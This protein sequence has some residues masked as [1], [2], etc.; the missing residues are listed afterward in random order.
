MK[1]ICKKKSDDFLVCLTHDVDWV[2]K[3]HQYLS[4]LFE[5]N[6]EG[7]RKINLYH[8][9]SLL[10]RKEPYWC[11][12]KIID[13]ENKFNVRSAFFFLSQIKS[14]FFELPS[15]SSYR[16][17]L[18]ETKVREMVQYLDLNG[19]EI[20]LHGSYYSYNNFNQLNEEKLRLEKVLG[21]KVKSVRQHYLNISIPETWEI[22]K[23]IGFD[24]DLTHGSNHST[25]FQ[26][27]LLDKRNFWTVGDR[28][29]DVHPQYFH[30]GNTDVFRPFNDDFF[31]IP[32]T[33]MDCS[34]FP[35]YKN[36]E[37]I[38]SKC[39]KTIKIAK[40]K[41]YILTINWHQ[42]SF[43]EKEYPNYSKLYSFIIECCM[44]ANAKFILPH[45]IP[46]FYE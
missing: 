16:Y 3:K 18:N 36:L 14:K 1:E 20:G 8:L 29:F 33:I 26:K 28:T 11:F 2:R 40:S 4:R 5:I 12:D 37:K 15:G 13:I 31:V 24:F 9:K 27:N 17:S 25:G 38:L 46:K 45:E 23:S 32:L 44:K 34:L 6:K 19:W 7:V 30:I 35:K 39:I 41:N 21:K 42:S 43:N 10:S 22:Q